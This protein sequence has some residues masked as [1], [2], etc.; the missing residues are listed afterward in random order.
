MKKIIWKQT[1]KYTKFNG[2]KMLGRTVR[3][4]KKSLWIRKCPMVRDAI[5][6]IIKYRWVGHLESIKDNRCAERLFNYC[7]IGS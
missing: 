4:R 1:E 6:V 7:P 5:K 3:G 2:K